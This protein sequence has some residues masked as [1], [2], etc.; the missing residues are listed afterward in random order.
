MITVY[1]LKNCDTCRKAL[2]WLQQEKI[3]YRFVDLRADGIARAD[4][5]R[6]AKAVGIEKLLNKAS[7]TWRGL[8]DDEKSLPDEAAAIA[9]MEKHPALIKR[10]VF[11]M[12]KTVIAGFRDAEKAAVRAAKA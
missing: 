1:G 9:L 4:I 10:P 12:G 3:A 5:A 11:D 7:T 8:A 2:A 6:F